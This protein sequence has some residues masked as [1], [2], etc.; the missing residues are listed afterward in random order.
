ME[1]FQKLSVGIKPKGYWEKIHGIIGIRRRPLPFLSQKD[2]R[3]KLHFARKFSGLFQSKDDIICEVI[4]LS[5]MYISYISLERP[6]FMD[7]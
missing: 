6:K 7:A 4:V 5:L 3:T 1:G 2:S